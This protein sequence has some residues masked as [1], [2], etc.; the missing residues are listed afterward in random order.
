MGVMK[1]IKLFLAAIMSVLF[2]F[3]LS[4]QKYTYHRVV[5][6]HGPDRVITKKIN[7]GIRSGELTKR[8]VKDLRREYRQIEK[9]KRKAWRNGHLSR[10]ERARIN[11]AMYDFERLLDRYLHNH[12]DRYD[13]YDRYDRHHR[14][15]YRD[16]WDWYNDDDYDYYYKGN[17]KS[18]K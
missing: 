3:T 1:T 2:V 11:H 7:K 18:H 12:R 4:A 13:R 10:R 5:K 15:R 6:Y 8:E 17:R 14:D 9:M 16:D